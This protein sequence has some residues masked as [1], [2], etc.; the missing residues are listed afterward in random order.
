MESDLPVA[1]PASHA[2]SNRISFEFDFRGPSQAVDTGCSSSLAAL[3]RGTERLRQRRCGLAVV[4]GVN[5]IAP[6]CG[7][8]A[9]ASENLDGGIGMVLLKRLDDALRDGDRIHAVVA[10][11]AENHGGRTLSLAAPSVEAQR[12]L[13]VAAYRQAG[14]GVAGIGHIELHG[15]GTAV[16]D[17]IECEAL[18]DA[19]TELR[20]RQ[21]VSREAPRC[22]LGAIGRRFGPLGAAGG[23]VGVIKTALMLRHRIIPGHPPLLDTRLVDLEGSGLEAV[24]EAARPWPA[25]HDTQPRCAGVSSF[26]ATGANA[27]AVL[28]EHVAVAIHRPA[29]MPP[30]DSARMFLLSA[31]SETALRAQARALA[32]HLARRTSACDIMADPRGQV[33]HDMA[34]TLQ[35]GRDALPWRFGV[36]ATTSDALQ[37]QLRLFGEDPT[38]GRAALAEFRVAHVEPLHPDF[39]D[40]ED[41]QALVRQWLEKG[42]WMHVLRLWLDGVSIDW[43]AAYR[44]RPGALTD[45]PPYP[46]PSTAALREAGTDGTVAEVHAGSCGG[47]SRG[48]RTHPSSAHRRTGT[49][50]TY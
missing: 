25:P 44:T 28:L 30:P 1:L 38:Q 12:E 18:R 39:S 21:A 11:V 9:R 10:A 8:D 43:R 4:G 3:A 13:L 7:E 24:G 31:H 32:A 48:R 33:L 34:Y 35:T 2:I 47:R 49:P 5:V 6:M 15:A 42:K 20:E 46:F 36:V 17:T 22:T 14:V 27:H 45:L 41:M 16:A 26:G 40:D 19:F 37:R 23:M 50:R 29:G